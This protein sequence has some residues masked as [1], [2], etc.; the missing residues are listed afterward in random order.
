MSSFATGLSSAFELTYE[1]S[2]KMLRQ[3]LNETAASPDEVER[4]AFPDL[5]RG[6]KR[7]GL[8]A[9]RLAGLAAVS[10]NARPHEP[11]L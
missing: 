3:Y 1:L 10:R 4:M 5:I 11:Y 2:H 6:W 9:G 8:T 7:S